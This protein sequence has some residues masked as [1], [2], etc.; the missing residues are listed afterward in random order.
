MRSRDGPLVIY[1]ILSTE[2]NLIIIEII[3]INEECFA[4][5]AIKIS[6]LCTN[7]EFAS[8]SCRIGL[9]VRDVRAFV[10]SRSANRAPANR[11][12]STI[13]NTISTFIIFTFMAADMDVPSNYFANVGAE[14]WIS[15]CNWIWYWNVKNWIR[16]IFIGDARYWH[17]FL[18]VRQQV[19]HM[20]FQCTFCLI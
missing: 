14:P 12:S 13:L 6:L 3:I 10:W 18:F 16:F 2:L 20:E 9:F 11:S 7:I 4:V 19:I 5:Y 17:I 8:S 1:M 15:L